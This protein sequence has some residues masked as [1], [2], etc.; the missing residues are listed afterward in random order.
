MTE[1]IVNDNRP[2]LFIRQGGWAASVMRATVELF[3]I[4]LVRAWARFIRQFSLFVG[5]FFNE[6]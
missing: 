2:A 4:S 5:I 6:C 3:R 1:F